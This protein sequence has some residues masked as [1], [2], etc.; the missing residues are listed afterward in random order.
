MGSA[1]AVG[2][3]TQ[4]YVSALP[5]VADVPT[6]L[7]ADPA[8]EQLTLRPRRGLATTSFAAASRIIVQ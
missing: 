5:R 7:K 8:A 2:E 6:S 1:I 3:L 4:D